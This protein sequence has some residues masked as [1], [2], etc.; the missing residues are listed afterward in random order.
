[1]NEKQNEKQKEQNPPSQKGK[2]R[3]S[4]GLAVCFAAAI[5]ITGAYTW[6]NYKDRTEQELSQ[7][8]QEAQAREDE[9]NQQAEAADGLAEKAGMEQKAG[10][11][12]TNGKP[13]D[14]AEKTGDNEEQTGQSAQTAGST[15]QVNFTEESQLL[16]PVDGNVVMS[17]SMDRTVYFPTLD[18]YRYNPAVI[19]AGAAGDSVIA[20]APG[21]VKS[22]DVLSQTGTTVTVDMGNGYECLYGQLKEVPV[23]VG[24]YVEAGTLL[25]YLSEPTKYYSV[26]G[27][28]LYFEM[29]K[30]GQPVNPID[31]MAEE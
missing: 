2:K 24:S 9:M 7:A 8:R 17:F 28:N 29:R 27:C 22:I 1:M 25:G 16:W 19:I 26:E 5:I 12:G 6:T 21:T 30:E 14:D 3:A 20:S 18:Q 4:I 31:Y 15:S 13:Q 23:T 10:E 11:S